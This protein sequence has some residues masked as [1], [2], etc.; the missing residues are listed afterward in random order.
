MLLVKLLITEFL[1]LPLS[2][3]VKIIFSFKDNLLR[4]LPKTG[5]F[6]KNL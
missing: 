3:F 5:I 6:Q 2:F 1:S 4:F